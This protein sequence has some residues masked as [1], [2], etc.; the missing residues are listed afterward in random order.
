M[1]QLDPL[2]Q[3]SLKDYSFFLLT[4]SNHERPKSNHQHTNYDHIR[5]FLSFLKINIIVSITIF[6]LLKYEICINLVVPFTRKLNQTIKGFLK[7]HTILFLPLIT[8]PFSCC[9]CISCERF[10]FKKTILTSIWCTSRISIVV[11][12]NKIQID[13]IHAT[14][15]K[16]WS[17]LIPSTYV[18]PLATKQG[19]CL[20]TKPSTLYLTLKIHLQFTSLWLGGN[21][22]CIQILLFCKD[23][24]LESIVFVQCC[25]SSS[26]KASIKNWGSSTSW[27]KTH[28]RFTSF[29]TIIG[30]FYTYWG[31]FLFYIFGSWCKTIYS[32]AKSNLE[33]II[34]LLKFIDSSKNIMID[35]NILAY[36]VV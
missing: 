12:T 21:G 3:I 16:V 27:H 26:F 8:K 29:S 24:N 1:F 6:K 25:E 19:L 32:Y 22:I 33:T 13:S 20:A 7:L 11:I 23:W 4:K 17:K 18:N 30:F 14:R 5:V 2:F 36:R 15:K 10:P 35:D 9:I 31:I 28:E 34:S